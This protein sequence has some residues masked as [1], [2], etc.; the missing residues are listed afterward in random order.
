MLEFSNLPRLSNFATRWLGCLDYRD[1]LA[2]QEA[3]FA[4]RVRDDIPDTLLLLE[5]PA[6]YTL[7]KSD[8]IRETIQGLPVYRADRGGGITFHG[9]GQLVGYPIFRLPK[10]EVSRLVDWIEESLVGLLSEVGIRGKQRRRWRGV[11]VGTRKIASIGL[12]VK[13][14]ISMHGFAL[15]LAPDL[16]AFDRILPCGLPIEMT[17]IE[18]EGGPCLTTERFAEM[19]CQVAL[20][21]WRGE[22]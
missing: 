16:R 10:G 21:R 17:S 9:P 6:C 13:R 22:E 14:G 19:L 15:N 12:K 20:P 2:L 3:L 18:R 1:A 7:G 8:E 11:W 5:H 4:R